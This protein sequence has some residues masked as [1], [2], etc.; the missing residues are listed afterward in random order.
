MLAA[1]LT[2][3]ELESAVNRGEL[4]RPRRG[5]YANRLADDDQLRAVVAGARIGC[6][7]A[8]RRWGVWSGEGDRLHLQVPRTSSGL[9]LREAPR[10]A[11]LRVPHPAWELPLDWAIRPCDAAGPVAHWVPPLQPHRALD[12]IVSPVDAL[13]QAVRCQREEHALACVDSALHEGVVTLAEWEAVLA[14]LPA[15]LRALDEYKDSRADSGNE[16]IVR[17]RLRRLGLRS[18][19]QVRLPGIGFIDLLVEGLVPLEVD[20]EAHHSSH[21]QRQRDRSRSLLSAALGS[22]TLRIGPE[23]LTAREWPLVVVAIDRQLADARGRTVNR[24]F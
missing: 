14:S 7:S 8:L 16:T 13:A 9:V 24:L 3:R 12:W 5:W 4:T 6:V 22:P 19:P 1:G 2:R 11:Q 15:R 18:E 23:H 17:L 21:G 10:G 20:S